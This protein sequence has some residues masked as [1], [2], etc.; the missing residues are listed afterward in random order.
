MDRARRAEPYSSA[1]I[2]TREVAKNL[3]GHL[4]R[5]SNAHSCVDTSSPKST[6]LPKF[7]HT[8]NSKRCGTSPVKTRKAL[9]DP[10]ATATEAANGAQDSNSST[11]RGEEESGDNQDEQKDTDPSDERQEAQTQPYQHKSRHQ[12]GHVKVVAPLK[13]PADFVLLPESDQDEVPHETR[14]TLDKVRVPGRLKAEGILGDSTY[15]C[16]PTI[17]NGK[18]RP[19]MDYK[20]KQAQLKIWQENQALAKR[21]RSTKPTLKSK[22]W[23]RDD[24]WNQEFLKTQER[25]RSLLQTEFVKAQTVPHTTIV[26]V[27]PLK[28]PHNETVKPD[29]LP[30]GEN[31]IIGRCNTS[32]VDGSELGSL[33]AREMRRRRSRSR[34]LEDNLFSGEETQ[35]LR[36]SAA[37]HRRIMQLRQQKCLQPTES[38]NDRKESAKMRVRDSTVDLN[39]DELVDVRFTFSRRRSHKTSR[40]QENG[41][42]AKKTDKVSESVDDPRIAAKYDEGKITVLSGASSPGIELEEALCRCDSEEPPPIQGTTDA[43]GSSEPR[44][45]SCQRMSA[46]ELTE[47]PGDD[48]GASKT[49]VDPHYLAGSTL[50]P[51]KCTSDCNHHEATDAGCAGISEEVSTGSDRD[52]GGITGVSDETETSLTQSDALEVANMHSVDS[53]PRSSGDVPVPLCEE[54]A[55]SIDHLAEGKVNTSEDQYVGSTTSNWMEA[56]DTDQQHVISNT[57]VVVALAKEEE[58]V[59]RM[60]ESAGSTPPERQQPD[61]ISAADVSLVEAELEYQD[62]ANDDDYQHDDDQ[63]GDNVEGEGMPAPSDDLTAKEALGEAAVGAEDDNEYGSEYEDDVEPD[64]DE[65]QAQTEALQHGAVAEEARGRE[66]EDEHDNE[67]EHDNEQDEYS[68]DGFAD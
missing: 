56:G 57:E 36:S 59:P 37:N 66:H 29:G 21:L 42:D 53:L 60:G 55:A 10:L 32:A 68:D 28:L 12:L 38:E 9:V 64:Q 27:R 18:L 67:H 15:D 11:G 54:S 22:D 46:S 25:R 7:Q 33:S 41:G 62:D 61:D 26:R 23:E 49:D 39:D 47:F 16:P 58:A 50:F 14:K 48:T 52:V 44:E 3:A 40:A 51:E 13:H 19:G 1:T 43:G 45:S 4:A 6:Q 34:T 24:K 65:E 63:T 20:Q 35:H 30:D 2:W 17:S 31:I 8:R 5:I